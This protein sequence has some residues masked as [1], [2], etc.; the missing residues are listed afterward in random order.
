M[1]I[2]KQLLSPQV[3]RNYID[4]SHRGRGNKAARRAIATERGK[5]HLL[6]ESEDIY[7]ERPEVLKRGSLLLIVDKHPHMIGK[8][9][10]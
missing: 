7:T 10:T 6:F 9:N 2:F 3:Q 5:E 1:N 8:I 4:R